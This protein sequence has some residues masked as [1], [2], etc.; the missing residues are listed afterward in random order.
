M[1]KQNFDNKEN[2]F[3]LSTQAMSFM[4]EMINAV[5]DLS[6][7]GG[8]N[9]ILSGCVKSGTQVSSGVIVLNGEILPFK[10]GAE[11][12]KIT[13]L[14]EKETVAANGIT[15]PDIRVK[16]YAAFASGSGENYFAW[17]DFKPLPTNTELSQMKADT[18]YVDRKMAEIT[19]G[20]IPSK[21]IVMWSGT[22][23]EVPEGWALCDGR[24]ASPGVFTPNLSGKFIV[25]YNRDDID[26]NQVGKTGGV[27]DVV[28]T[29]EQMPTHSHQ[30]KDY[31]RRESYMQPGGADKDIG[32]DNA[33][34]KGDGD[35]GVDRGC[36]YF[37][38]KKH[39][40]EEIGGSEAH[41]NRPPYYVLA[42]IIKL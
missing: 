12:T 32:I 10:G 9:Y 26:Y 30:V 31:F 19:A 1:N 24:E 34:I 20:S 11:G 3:P 39:L 21:V 42:Y 15:F 16:R 22:E 36:Q 13:V 33:G 5:A 4:Q 41:E 25:G 14:E 7:I 27:K 8:E 29:P 35:D 37:W 40:T 18:D 6:R 28:L 2:R 17:N 23:G 38:W